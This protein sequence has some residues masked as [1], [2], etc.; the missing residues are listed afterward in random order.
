[1]V[2]QVLNRVCYGDPNPSYYQA[3]LLTITPAILPAFT[4]YRVRYCDYPAIVP[5]SLSSSVRGTYVRGLTDGDI[6][7]LDI[8]EGPEYKREKVKI[9]VLDKVGNDVGQGNV[10]GDQV[11]VETYIWIAG[12]E[13]LEDCEWDFAEFKREKLRSWVYVDDHYGGKFRLNYPTHVV[14]DSR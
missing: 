13:A 8:F 5:S 2:R 7:R 12:N 1:M 4:R 14:L 11:E 9:R 6:W 3:N 10:E